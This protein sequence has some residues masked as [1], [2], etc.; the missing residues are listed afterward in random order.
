[1]KFNKTAYHIVFWL[2]AYLFWIFVF[3]N[4]TLVLT[5]AITIQFCYLLFISANYYFN[6]FY[7]IP[8]LLNKKR[9]ALFAF[10]FLLGISLTAAVRVPVSMF[11]TI[12]VFKVAYPQFNYLSIFADSF[13]NI[14]FWVLCILA[15]KMI[16]EK[17][18][19]QV[20]IEKIEKEKATNEL[21]FL[22]A[23]FNP[24]FLF[25]S[26]NSI[27]G[28]IDKSNKAARE[29]LLVF[30][31]MLRYQL[32]ECNV[33]RI[34][35][36]SEVNYIKN[37]IAIQKGRIDE[38]ILVSF[39]ACDINEPVYI[40]PLLFVA[41]VENAFKYV[42]FNEHR[43]N[44]VDI[45]LKYQN[46]DLWLRVY[47]T[48]DVFTGS[49]EERSCGLGIANTRR[50]LEILYPQKH[51]LEITDSIDSFEVNLTLTGV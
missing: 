41:F 32:Y 27:Y 39:C 45:S 42:G 15:A 2:L 35:L 44:L 31:E 37:Y 24:H 38:R 21:N 7:T 14:L 40:A 16:I 19:S 28:H 20:Y 46:G 43:I 26:I 1:M 4:G 51:K 11:V 13:V 48:K 5:H 22:R 10:M 50:R 29:M 8:V 25:N 36:E 12:Y 47:N 30:S 6:A 33:E 49:R 23:Q 34:S 9:Y 17:I 18:R 3:R